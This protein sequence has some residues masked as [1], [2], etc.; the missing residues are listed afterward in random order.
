MAGWDQAY[1]SS[2]LESLSQ[3]PLCCCQDFGPAN[4]GVSSK[5]G[6]QCGVPTAR[7][8][9]RRRTFVSKTVKGLLRSS[10]T[11]GFAV[12]RID[13]HFQDSALFFQ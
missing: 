6:P 4:S 12:K 1:K 11:E 3:E 2:L 9:K 7:D 5:Q 13:R 10:D 8:S